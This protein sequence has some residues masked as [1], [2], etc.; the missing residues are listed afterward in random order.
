MFNEFMNTQKKNRVSLLVTLVTGAMLVGC[1]TPAAQSPA[2]GAAAILVNG[3]GSTFVQP[4]IENLAFTY[5]QVD[6][7][8]QINYSG[9][10][11]GQGKKDILANTVDF[12]GSD[13]A[14]TDAEFAQKPLQQLP[15]IAGAEV[16]I[17]NLSELKDPLV[18]DGATAAGIYVGKI[19]KWNDPAIA[20]LNPGVTLPDKAINVVHRSD[21]SGT[22]NIFTLYLTAVS[23]D[24]VNTVKPSAGTTVDWPVDKLKRGQGGKGN[25]GVAAAVKQTAGAIGYVELAYGVNNKIPFTKLVNAAGKTVEASPASTTAAMKGVQ[26]SERLTANIVNSS[27]AEAWPI[28]GFTYVVLNKDYAD[29]AKAEKLLKWVDWTLTNKDAQDHATKLLYAVLPADAVS[30]AEAALKQ[31]TC[32]GTVVLK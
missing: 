21:G 29:C 5:K 25:Q 26:F 18:L 7:S 30:K 11:S 8:V 19:E 10:G 16:L 31:I 24:W 20:K 32:K 15:I 4:L 13:A 27:D 9:G 14:L 28:S 22:T 3:S 2:G 1:G 12:A 23:P 17:Y 6:S